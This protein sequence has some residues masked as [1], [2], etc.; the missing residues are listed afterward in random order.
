MTDAESGESER[1]WQVPHRWL[2]EAGRGRGPRNA[3]PPL[4]AGRGE[5]AHSRPGPP[6]GAQP[7][8]RLDWGPGILFRTSR[9]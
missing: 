7:C 6:R 5:D 4:A 8:Q 1:D 9:T 2:R 3:G